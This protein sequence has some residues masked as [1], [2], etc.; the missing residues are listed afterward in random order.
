MD[1]AQN[2]PHRSPDQETIPLL[3]RHFGSWCFTVSRHVQSRCDLSHQYDTAAKHWQETASRFQLEAAYREPLINSGIPEALINDIGEAAVLDCGIG[4]GSLS[5]ALS[6][7]VSSR[8]AYHGIDISSGMLEAAEIAMRQEEIAPTLKQADVLSIPYADNTFDLVMSAHVLE[9]LP[10]PRQALKEM[11]RVLK[12]GGR[13][14][15]CMTRRSLFGALIQLL[16]RTWAVTTEQGTAWLRDCELA[17]VGSQ[18][19][20]LGTFAREASTAFW[21]R[22]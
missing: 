3:S 2:I 14:F 8:I 6:G 16:W 20:N 7:A 17:E 18:P 1:I 12:P 4:S 15:V 5:V 13:L 11:I 21:A 9:H 10:E 19:I 22:K